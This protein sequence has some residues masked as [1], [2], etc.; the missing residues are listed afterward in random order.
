V[1]TSELTRRK[2]THLRNCQPCRLS[3]HAVSLSLGKE[4]VLRE[5]YRAK[6]TMHLTF[7]RIP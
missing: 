7:Q 4:E 1:P 5:H 3:R 6:H 2:P